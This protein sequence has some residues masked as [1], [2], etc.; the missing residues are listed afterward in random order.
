MLEESTGNF[1]STRN[2]YDWYQTNTHVIINVG[3]KN[4]KEADVKVKLID[5][6]LD[7][8]C[9]LADGNVFRLHFNLHKPIY[10]SDSNWMVTPSKLEIKLKKT[11]RK[12]WQ[13]LEHL[14]EK[15][16]KRLNTGS[17]QGSSANATS[18][19]YLNSVNSSNASGVMNNRSISS[20][21]PSGTSNIVCTTLSP[22]GSRV[23]NATSG[24]NG[25]GATSTSSHNI[26][27]V[28]KAQLLTFSGNYRN[29]SPP[30]P[31][32]DWFQNDTHVIVA[33]H[34]RNLTDEDVSVEFEEDRLDV[35]CKC[36]DG[37]IFKIDVSLH[38]QI[39]PKESDYSITPSK[40]EIRMRKASKGRWSNL[41]TSPE[42]IKSESSSFGPSDLG[43][44]EA[45][46]TTI[47]LVQECV[48][49]ANIEPSESSKTELQ[50][51]ESSSPRIITTLVPIEP[52]S[53]SEVS[54][55]D[56]NTNTTT[57]II[58]TVE[59]EP[60]S[61][62][63]TTLIDSIGE[64][65]TSLEAIERRTTESILNSIIDTTE[66][67]VTLETVETSTVP[68]GDEIHTLCEAD[69]SDHNGDHQSII[70]ITAVENENSTANLNSECV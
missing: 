68:D 17:G 63:P 12:R 13:S 65:E 66:E 9:S 18:S 45:G 31:K 22:S 33:V 56:C 48:Q 54:S 52:N 57:I 16:S 62:P 47:D 29:L 19:P 67:P 15:S 51:F 11:D 1:S 14:P 44:N 39:V 32:H 21:S 37:T 64:N 35:E 61:D 40:L 38:S 42:I 25:S 8:T 49:S 10:V 70:T 60:P 59:A 69:A 3:L 53:D 43:K 23:L 20:I 2:M 50:E 4:L 58:E 27:T 5:E 7:V 46:H 55:R 26:T 30:K 28:H 36:E 24:S 6:T 34:I 41:E